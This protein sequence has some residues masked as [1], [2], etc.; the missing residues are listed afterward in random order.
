VTPGVYNNCAA[1]ACQEGL[2][3]IE[4]ANEDKFTI[5]HPK[6]PLYNFVM[7]K[8][9]HQKTLAFLKQTGSEIAGFEF[10]PRGN[11]LLC[12]DANVAN[13]NYGRRQEEALTRV[14]GI[15]LSG[16]RSGGCVLSERV[17]SA[18]WQGRFSVRCFSRYGN[19]D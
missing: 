17:R 18:V 14:T 11:E 13:T 19:F 2:C 8:V 7:P 4:P 9:P 6:N 1:D 3:G 10:M 12:I 16:H 5:L 15:A